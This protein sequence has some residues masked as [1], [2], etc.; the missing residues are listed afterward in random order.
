MKNKRLSSFFFLLASICSFVA[1]YLS[2][3]DG[4]I[5]G[6]RFYLQGF[7][8]TLF[9]ILACIMFIKSRASNNSE[10]VK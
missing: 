6:Y 10:E 7:N 4:D 1:F 5:S 3:K 9:L 8:G 2:I